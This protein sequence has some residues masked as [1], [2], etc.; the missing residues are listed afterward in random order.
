MK[1]YGTQKYILLKLVIIGK[2]TQLNRSIFKRCRG[3]ELLVGQEFQDETFFDLY[4]ELCCKTF[5]K[6]PGNVSQKIQSEGI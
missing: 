4:K 6:F 5:G 1:H 2:K 3:Y